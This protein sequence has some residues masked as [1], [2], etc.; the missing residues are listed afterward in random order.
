MRFRETPDLSTGAMVGD[1]LFGLREMLD[2]PFVFY[3]HSLGGLLA[4]EL[5]RQLQA[6]GLPLPEHLFIGAT[7]PPHMGLIHEELH[8][9]PDK[10]FVSAIQNRYAGIPAAVLEEPELMEMFLPALKADFTAYERYWFEETAPVACR[11]TAFRGESDPGI[12]PGLMDEWAPHT[13]GEFKL[14]TVPGD[15]FF[16]TESAEFV[17]GEIRKSLDVGKKSGHEPM[18]PA[19]LVASE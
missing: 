14:H 17:L 13:S 6:Q 3:G 12:A 5:T 8:H 15:H 19:A 7:V 16:L 9:L 10:Q 18:R 1:F 11:L 2:L 4:F